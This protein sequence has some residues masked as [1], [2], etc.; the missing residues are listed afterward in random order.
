MGG[1]L[2]GVLTDAVGIDESRFEIEQ[3]PEGILLITMQG[4]ELIDGLMSLRFA[5]GRGA[6]TGRCG[7][8]GGGVTEVIVALS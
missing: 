3:A 2:M 5:S 7:P 8:A 6:R 4:K 1:G